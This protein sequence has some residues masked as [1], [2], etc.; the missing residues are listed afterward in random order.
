MLNQTLR[1]GL[2]SSNITINGSRNMPS[3]YWAT[4]TPHTLKVVEIHASRPMKRFGQAMG[5]ELTKLYALKIEI[6]NLETSWES[7]RFFNPRG[8][9]AR[10]VAGIH[11][12]PKAW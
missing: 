5:I 1:N 8:L 3:K 11:K 6:P 12:C 7:F 4:I 10:S 9:E 2:E